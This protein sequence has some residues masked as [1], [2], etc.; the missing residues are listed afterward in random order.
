MCRY[1]V[2]DAIYA[3]QLAIDFGLPRFSIQSVINTAFACSFVLQQY[4]QQSHATHAIAR[5]M[6]AAAAPGLDR[7]MEENGACAGT[8]SLAAC[9][10][11]LT[12]K[13]RESVLIE[14]LPA[15]FEEAAATAG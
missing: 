7:F 6:L 12:E 14:P 13:V 15:Y 9:I 11:T 1:A 5:E 8:V 10:D 2:V 3:A 4:P